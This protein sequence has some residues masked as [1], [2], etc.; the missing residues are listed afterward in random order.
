MR[1]SPGKEQDA[2][3]V[4]SPENPRAGKDLMQ[5]HSHK[6]GQGSAQAPG[7]QLMGRKDVA[8]EEQGVATE[9]VVIWAIQAE[10]EFILWYINW[11]FL[12]PTRT[13]GFGEY[14]ALF[15]FFMAIINSAAACEAG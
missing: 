10:L 1:H 14:G 15:L 2:G 12:V 9:S 6:S 8:P 13:T 5:Q 7:Q 3:P 4:F 11:A